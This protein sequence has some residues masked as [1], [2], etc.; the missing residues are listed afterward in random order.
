MYGTSVYLTN[1]PY[2]FFDVLDRNFKSKMSKTLFLFGILIKRIKLVEELSSV[3]SKN[4][5]SFNIRF[6]D[7]INVDLV[8]ENLLTDAEK[9]ET[10]PNMEDIEIN[11]GKTYVFTSRCKDIMSEMI[12]VPLEIS[13]CLKR[14]VEGAIFHSWKQ[15]FISLIKKSESSG[16]TNSLHLLITEQFHNQA[17]TVIGSC[18]FIIRI[19]CFGQSLLTSFCIDIES[20][21]DNFI[22]DLNKTEFKCRNFEKAI[23][24]KKELPL[25]AISWH[26]LA[27]RDDISFKDDEE[28]FGEVFF[29]EDNSLFR[30]SVSFDVISLCFRPTEKKYIDFTALVSADVTT[31][32]KGTCVVLTVEKQY[33]QS[34]DLKGTQIILNPLHSMETKLTKKLCN[35]TACP[36][37]IKL[38]EYGYGPLATSKGIGAVYGELKSSVSYGL[39][40]TYGTFSR[41]GPY[42]IL[43]DKDE[44]S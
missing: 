1:L 21:S 36:A 22:N 39:S 3:K 35:K 2:V 42:G 24:E 18:D 34:G 32:S 41:Y 28:V 20:D 29:H 12:D 17:D 10:M 13:L 8:L 16:E 23:T 5:I 30:D 26:S 25:F 38:K 33:K 44:N 15:N 37:A 31:T 27:G 19:S 14:K 9:D 6:S 43:I 7:F 4:D 40:Q 11:M